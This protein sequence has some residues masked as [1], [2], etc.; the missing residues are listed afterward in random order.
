MKLTVDCVLSKQQ[1]IYIGQV[2]IPSLEEKPLTI[3]IKKL[4]PKEWCLRAST[5]YYDY[6]WLR[7][8]WMKWN[9]ERRYY[10]VEGSQGYHRFTSLQEVLDTLNNMNLY[11]KSTKED[12]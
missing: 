12:V 7:G 10:M 9:D 2:S 8:Q 1:E 6:Y 4:G 5:S 3:R 11:Y